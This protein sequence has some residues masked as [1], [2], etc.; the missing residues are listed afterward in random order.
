MLRSSLFFLW[1]GWVL[2]VG[3]IAVVRGVY[4][5]RE[6]A[7]REQQ[8]VERAS[9]RAESTQHSARQLSHLSRPAPLQPDYRQHLVDAGIIRPAGDPT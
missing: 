6:G 4:A 5:K 7:E 3:V 9:R 2:V 1:I 8:R